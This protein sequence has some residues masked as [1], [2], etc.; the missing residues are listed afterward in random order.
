M[1]LDGFANGTP[2]FGRL[3][4]QAHKRFGFAELSTVADRPQKP[5]NGLRVGLVGTWR[6]MS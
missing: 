3:T 4:L 5:G 2:A 6:A 1:S